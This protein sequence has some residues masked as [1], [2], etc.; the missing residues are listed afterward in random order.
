[1]KKQKIKYDWFEKQK[2]KKPSTDVG[3]VH[4]YY[5]EQP[6]KGSPIEKKKQLEQAKGLLKKWIEP[7]YDREELLYLTEQFLS[8]AEK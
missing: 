1:M 2:L 7:K 5:V 6:Y 8:E 4:G 3:E